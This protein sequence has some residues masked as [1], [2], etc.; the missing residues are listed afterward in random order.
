MR[1]G[2]VVTRANAPDSPD[3]TPFPA[4]MRPPIACPVPS[5]EQ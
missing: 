2:S 3:T 5:S 1:C 4:G